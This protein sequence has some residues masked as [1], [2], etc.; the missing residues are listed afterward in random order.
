M[1]VVV[2][3]KGVTGCR[4]NVCA[5][6]CHGPAIHSLVFFTL[7]GIPKLVTRFGS[8]EVL[9]ASLFA[10]C[11]CVMVWPALTYAAMVGPGMLWF[12]IVVVRALRVAL[13]GVPRRFPVSA[14]ACVQAGRGVWRATQ[15][16]KSYRRP[17][18]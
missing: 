11:F 17:C 4:R 6:R 13:V 7:Y 16:W 12:C 2:V 18:C 1:V 14:C 10:C 15:A 5:C 8:V 9:R 3:W